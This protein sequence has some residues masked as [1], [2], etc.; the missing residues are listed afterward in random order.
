MLIQTQVHMWDS[1]RRCLRSEPSLWLFSIRV[2]WALSLQAPLIPFCHLCLLYGSPH[3][4]RSSTLGPPLS[5][6]LHTCLS[7]SSPSPW[8]FPPPSSQDYFCLTSAPSGFSFALPAFLIPDLGEGVDHLPS[9][10]PCLKPP[11]GCCPRQ[12]S[13]GHSQVPTLHPGGLILNFHTS[14]L[15]D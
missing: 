6:T 9:L 8:P 15:Y 12:T 7:C 4:L 13:V 14:L 1:D 2:L 5:K 11:E 10:L 3:V